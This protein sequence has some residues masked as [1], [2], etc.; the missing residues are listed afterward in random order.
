VLYLGRDVEGIGIRNEDGGKGAIEK[1]SGK[2]GLEKVAKRRIDAY[3]RETTG[4]RTT[5]KEMN[6]KSYERLF[7]G[8][9]I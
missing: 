1:V 4:H 7:E 3:H 8:G 9:N 6:A 2:G 5:R